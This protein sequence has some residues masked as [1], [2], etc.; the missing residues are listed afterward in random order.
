MQRDE[1][2]FSCRR[3]ETHA[4]QSGC[5]EGEKKDGLDEGK[6]DFS[7]AARA[8]RREGGLARLGLALACRAG[9]AGRLADA[10][11]W[12]ATNWCRVGG[13]KEMR[14]RTR[15]RQTGREG[16]GYGGMGCAFSGSAKRP[17][18]E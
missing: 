9:L 13:N 5:R 17:A 14:G 4:C 16:T 12:L 18:G 6:R 8:D 15:A 1:T 2:E 10:L 11:G 7:V 3:R